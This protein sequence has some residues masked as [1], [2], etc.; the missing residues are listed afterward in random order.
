MRPSRFICVAVSCSPPLTDGRDK[1][2]QILIPP[3][4]ITLRVLYLGTASR[5]KI[6]EH[7][8]VHS[9][10][11][12]VVHRREHI[13]DLLH[14]RTISQFPCLLPGKFGPSPHAMPS[15]NMNHDHALSPSSTRLPESPTYPRPFGYQHK[16]HIASFFTPGPVLRL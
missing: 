9:L 14:F 16:I 8:D 15:M 5:R 11:Y 6:S 13:S 3:P 7:R 1:K 10:L 12:S 2:A 4:M